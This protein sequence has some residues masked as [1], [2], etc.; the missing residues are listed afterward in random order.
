MAAIQNSNKVS[1]VINR[2]RHICLHV[3]SQVF[4]LATGIEKW[5]LLKVTALVILKM[6]VNGAYS[7]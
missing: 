7:K 3:T 1:R 4:T 6:A 2:T 5:R